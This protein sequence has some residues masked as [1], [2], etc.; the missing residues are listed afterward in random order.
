M[1]FNFD[2]VPSWAHTWCFYFMFMG[3]MSI[4]TGVGAVI[5]GKKIGF[6]VAAAYMVA[7]LVQAATAFTMFWMCRSSL[8]PQAA[9]LAQFTH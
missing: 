4:L 5:Y 6:G 9:A 7:A 1:A 3:V 8:K 2:D